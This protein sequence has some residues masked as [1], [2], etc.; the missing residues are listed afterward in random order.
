VKM[1]A[2]SPKPKIACLANGPYYPL[3]RSHAGPGAAPSPRQWRCMH[4]G[5]RHRALPL[6]RLRQQ[7]I[8]RRHPRHE[9]IHRSKAR[10]CQPG[11]A[12]ELRGEAGHDPRQP[13]ALR[14][15]RPSARTG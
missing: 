11:S 4:H 12:H 13:R 3:R 15:R 8:L 7:A 1:S 6:R 2:A 14:P 9:R 5:A 10:R